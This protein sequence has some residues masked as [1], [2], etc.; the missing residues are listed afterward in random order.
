M[1]KEFVYNSSTMS[2]RSAVATKYNKS[3]K[4][5]KG[6]VVYTYLT[7]CEMFQMPKEIKQTMLSFLDR[8]HMLGIISYQSE[9]VLLASE[10]VLGVYQRLDSTNA[11]TSE[12]I[13]N[14]LVGLIIAQNSRFRKKN[15]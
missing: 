11:I 1:V 5:C 2:L 13:Q 9:H 14:V 6:G 15:V 4:N 7:L 12:H 8:F 10:E 3:R